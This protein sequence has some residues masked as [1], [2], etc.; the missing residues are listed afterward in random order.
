MAYT[1]SLQ[2]APIPAS[3]E[4]ALVGLVTASVRACVRIIY[5]PAVLCTQQCSHNAPLRQASNAVKIYMQPNAQFGWTV[6]A[7]PP[8]G[9]REGRDTPQVTALRPR[10][11]LSSL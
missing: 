8:A 9:G 5:P 1:V 6:C 4:R 10:G 7:R 2:G 3:A 11:P